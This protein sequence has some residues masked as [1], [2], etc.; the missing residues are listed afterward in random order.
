MKYT[1]G[2]W[3]VS[4]SIRTAINSKNKHIAMVNYSHRGA[5]SDVFGEEHLANAALIAAAPDMLE[6]LEGAER[7]LTWME[8]GHAHKEPEPQPIRERIQEAIAK[9]KGEA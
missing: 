5:P 4:D 9:A 2:P 8:S 3:K 6:A 7:L 1:Q